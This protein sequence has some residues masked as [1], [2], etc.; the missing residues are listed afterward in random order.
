[1]NAARCF[2]DHLFRRRIIRVEHALLTG[3]EEFC[4]CF[5]VFLHGLMEVQMILRQIGKRPDLKANSLHPVQCQR[6]G[7]YLHH[8]MRASGIAHPRQ[9][10]LQGKALRRGALRL[11][12]FAADHVPDGPDEA[13]LCTAAGFKHFLHKAG[14]GGLAVGTGHADHL[15]GVRRVPVPV[16]AEPCQCRPCRGHLHPWRRFR[17]GVFAEHRRRAALKRHRNKTVAVRGVAGN[18]DKQVARPGRTRI[19]AHTADF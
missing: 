12:F 17:H 7:G 14:D 15:H 19:V 8:H 18:R 10:S 3:A 16:G 1:M 2:C 6:V 4:L 11:E 5:A 9:K 13:H